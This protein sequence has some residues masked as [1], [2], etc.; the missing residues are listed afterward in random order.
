MVQLQVG[1]RV[2][3]QPQL[4]TRAGLDSY[5]SSFRVEEDEVLV[6]TRVY[7]ES[8]LARGPLCNG[9]DVSIR[10]PN[11]HIVSVNGADPVT[12]VA[13]RK[14]GTKPDDTEDMTYIGLDHPG[15]QWL[16]EDMGKYA[17]GKN[18][19]AEYDALCVRLGIPARPRPHLVF[20]DSA[21]PRCKGTCQG[22]RAARFP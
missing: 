18:W 22:S 3:L 9:Q 6:V 19:C 10:S 7:R 20:A 13:P 8:F 11:D 15:I 1:D 4:Y 17:D 21:I 14:L 5:P 16:F 2:T 12:G